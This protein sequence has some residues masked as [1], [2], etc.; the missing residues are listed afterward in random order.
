LRA[1]EFTDAEIAIV[2]LYN[3]ACDEFD[4]LIKRKQA[5]NGKADGSE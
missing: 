3:A 5:E 2:K 4:A 1:T